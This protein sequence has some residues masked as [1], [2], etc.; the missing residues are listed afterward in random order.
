LGVN[1][2]NFGKWGEKK[3]FFFFFFFCRFDFKIHVFI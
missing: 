2:I 1:L 3:H